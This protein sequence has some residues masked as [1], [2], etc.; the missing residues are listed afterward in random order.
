MPH[1][2]S[3]GLIVQDMKKSLD[4]YRQLGIEIAPEMDSE[5]HVEAQLP[6][7]MRLMWDTVEVIHSFNPDWRPPSGGGRVGL[8]FLCENPAEVD[9]AYNRMIAVGAHSVKAPW[10]AFWGQRYA[11]I[12][13]PDGN[14][15]SLFAAL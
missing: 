8:N 4:F 5:D 11:V 9:A 7:G 10:D 1:F 13:D 6:G 2:E 15:V 3:I 12:E 14:E